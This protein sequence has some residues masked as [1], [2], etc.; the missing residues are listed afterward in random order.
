MEDD[1]PSKLVVL[2]VLVLDLIAFGFI[3]ATEG[4]RS[5]SRVLSNNYDETIYCVYDSY[6][7]TSYGVGVLLFLLVS[8]VLIMGVTKHLCYGFDLKPGIS[9]AWAIILFLMS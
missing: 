5:T 6:I 4:R 9:H 2:L 1:K 7:T 3:V 8:Q